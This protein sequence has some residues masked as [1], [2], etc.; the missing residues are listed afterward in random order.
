MREDDE[1]M[2]IYRT[3]QGQD[4]E[5]AARQAAEWLQVM[6][7]DPAVAERTEFVAW[8][9]ASPLNLREFLMADMVG[10]MLPASA[11]MDRLDV[12]AAVAAMRADNVVPLH[13]TADAHVRARRSRWRM[14][15][16]Q[17]VAA[18]CVLLV[19]AAAWLGTRPPAG[20]G[21]EYSTAIG[22][23]KTVLL[24]DGSGVLL[25]PRS[26]ISV[27]YGAGSREIDLAEGE[28]KFTVAHDAARP[29]RVHSDRSLVQAVGTQFTV[30]RLPSGTF[31]TVSEGKVKVSSAAASPGDGVVQ[32]L[33]R[34]VVRAP[35]VPTPSAVRAGKMEQAVESLAT[36]VPL[37]AGE[38]AHIP[39]G[40]RVLQ[41]EAVDN[42]GQA[43]ADG[44]SGRRLLFHDD[45]LADIAEAFNRYNARQITLGDASI[46]TQRYSG[47]FDANDPD[48]FLQFL[49][50]C[51]QVSV[52]PRRDDVLVTAA[53]VR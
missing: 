6:R 23:E 47:V 2:K 36:P 28:A 12:D 46:G 4:T 52:Q 15:W 37:V 31:V 18:A 41:R 45:T 40:T 14:P 5:R 53:R 9:Q 50:C 1:A 19:G 30:N 49:D 10:S 3:S 48:S 51:A 38:A 7:A 29:F 25:Y 44:T 13:P 35:A 8:L 26:R 33:S 21:V 11:A 32:W 17:S 20:A 39:L 22:E 24:A 27:R 16:L 34:M 42:G 43:N